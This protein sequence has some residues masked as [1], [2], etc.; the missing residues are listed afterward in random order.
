MKQY[1]N[2]LEAEELDGFW[3]TC[4][5]KQVWN[6]QIEMAMALLE[7]CKRHHL[8][9]WAISGTLLGAVR[10]KGF[11]PWDDDIDFVMFREDYDRLVQIAP[12]EFKSPLYFQCAYTEKGYYRG[13]AQIRYDGTTMI[14]PFNG[15]MGASFHQGIFIDIFVADGFPED[16]RKRNR[17]ISQRDMIQNYLWGRRYPLSW[18]S[19]MSSFTKYVIYK[20]R[21]REKTSWTDLELYAYMEDL[22]RKYAIKDYDRNCH[23]QFSY[24]PR[25]VRKT[26]WF[27]DT[28]WLPFERVEFPVPAKYHEMLLHE[29]GDYMTPIKGGSVHGAVIIDT[30]KSYKEYLPGMKISYLQA[31]Y[32]CV[33]SIGGFMLRIVG[34]KSKRN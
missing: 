6:I 27:E 25:W 7:V 29:Y 18:L 26:E 11:I 33:R 21:L 14:L 16:E 15:R 17:L 4:Q 3:V 22:H 9:I 10:H 8:R 1:V 19:S 20:F 12:A 28:V 24:L 32:M 31:A 2:S 5:S 34:L 30:E 13:H 23:L